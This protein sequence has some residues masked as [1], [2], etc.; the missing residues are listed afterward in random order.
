[1]ATQTVYQAKIDIVADG[2][3]AKKEFKSLG[4]NLTQIVQVGNSMRLGGNLAADINKASRSAQQLQ[5]HLSNAINDG[6]LNMNKFNASLKASGTNVQALTAN[7]TQTGSAGVNA[8]IGLSNQIVAA[9]A[10][11]RATNALLAKM[12]ST[13]MN[14]IRW[15]ISSSLIMGFTGSIRRAFNYVSDLSSELSKIRV[16]TGYSRKEMDELAKSANK[17]AKNLKASTLEVIRGQL[18]YQQQGDSMELAA[19]KAELT[20]KATATAVHASAEEMSNYLTAVWNSYKVGEDQLESFVDK[21][22]A[23]GAKTAASQEEIFTAMEKSAAAANAVGVSYDQLGA[24]IATISS[25][26]RNSAETIGTTLKTVYARI[27]DLK[28]EGPD[29]DGIGLGQVSSTLQKVGIEILDTKSELRDMGVV[30]EEIGEKYQT[31]SEAQQAA[32]VQAIAGKRQYTQMLALF[33]NWD[34]YKMNLDISLNADGTLE[35]QYKE[36]TDNIQSATK[37][38]SAELEGIWQNLLDD[39]A[40]ISIVNGF[41]FVI[42]IIGNTVESLGGFKG[43]LLT[44]GML[45]STKFVMPVVNGLN[46]IKGQ[47]GYLTGKTLQEHITAVQHLGAVS[48]T[49]LV[50][51]S[52]LLTQETQLEFKAIAIRA[53]ARAQYL[54]NEEQLSAVQKQRYQNLLLELDLLTKITQE[55]VARANADIS[56]LGTSMGAAI[57]SRKTKSGTSSIPGFSSRTIDNDIIITDSSERDALQQQL[58][59]KEQKRGSVGRKNKK[60][61]DKD[62]ASLSKKIEETP[63]SEYSYTDKM[64]EYTKQYTQ[65]Q[66][67]KIIADDALTRSSEM[68]KSGGTMGS[69]QISALQSSIQQAGVTDLGNLPTQLQDALTKVQGLKQDLSSLD[70]GEG[71][72]ADFNELVTKLQQ[73]DISLDDFNA[74]LKTL[75]MKDS[76]KQ[77]AKD[78]AKELKNVKVNFDDLQ[79]EDLS[80]LQEQFNALKNKIDSGLDKQLDETIA[81]M[82]QLQKKAG[83]SGPEGSKVVD[84]AIKAGNSQAAVNAGKIQTNITGDELVNTTKIDAQIQKM[85]QFTKSLQDV[86]AA[87]MGLSMLKNA[88]DF[89]NEMGPLERLTQ[90]L[91]SLGMILPIVTAAYKAYSLAKQK[92]AAITVGTFVVEKAKMVLVALKNMVIAIGRAVLG[93]VSALPAAIA[94][95][96]IAGA[97]VAGGIAIASAK[98]KKE[99]ED[100]LEKNRGQALQ[101]LSKKTEELAK[102]TEDLYSSYDKFKSLRDTINSMKEGT[103]EWLQKTMEL[104]TEIEKLLQLYPILKDYVITDDKGNYIGIK[105]EGI[106]LQAGIN[107]SRAMGQSKTTQGT[108]SKPEFKDMSVEVA[109]TQKSNYEKGFTYNQYSNETITQDM[110][111][112]ILR[113]NPDLDAYFKKNEE[114]KGEIGLKYVEWTDSDKQKIRLYA[115]QKKEYDEKYGEY[116]V[117]E[118]VLRNNIQSRKADKTYYD[119]T[120]NE[121]KEIQWIT[122]NSSKFR[123]DAIDSQYEQNVSDLSEDEMDKRLKA[124]LGDNFESIVGDTKEDKRKYLARVYASESGLAG[125]TTAKQELTQYSEELDKEVRAQLKSAMP[126]AKPENMTDEEWKSYKDLYGDILDANGNLVDGK[127]EEFQLVKNIFLR[128]GKITTEILAQGKEQAKTARVVTDYD[129]Q[130]IKNISTLSTMYQKVNSG[131]RL[132]VEDIKQISDSMSGIIENTSDWANKLYEARGNAQE[133]QKILAEM[134]S[135]AIASE[136]ANGRF[137]GMTIAQI[138]AFLENMGLTEAAAARV[139]KQISSMQNLMNDMDFKDA[140]L[141]VKNTE[142]ALNELA[143]KFNISGEMAKWAYYQIHYLDGMGV[144]FSDLNVALDETTGKYAR[145]AGTA[146]TAAEAMI[147]AEFAGK[148]S[149]EKDKYLVSR[150]YEKR[151][152]ELGKNDGGLWYDA[153]G[154]QI[155]WKEALTREIVADMQKGLGGSFT[156]SIN[157]LTTGKNSGNSDPKEDS[158]FDS[159]I[160]EIEKWDEQETEEQTELEEKIQDAIDNQDYDTALNLL[161][162]LRQKRVEKYKAWEEKI[163][164][165]YSTLETEFQNKHGASFEHMAERYYDDGTKKD[166]FTKVYN[167][168]SAEEQKMWDERAKDYS[169]S[170]E[171]INWSKEQLEVEGKEITDTGNQIFDV[172]KNKRDKVINR[173]ADQDTILDNIY[174]KSYL[175]QYESDTLNYEEYKAYENWLTKDLGLSADDPR[176]IE[177]QKETSEALKKVKDTIRE[178]LEAESFAYIDDGIKFGFRNDSLIKAWDRTWSHIFDE[179][180]KEKFATD[181]EGYKELVNMTYDKFVDS[182]SSIMEVA[183]EQLLE[184]LENRMAKYEG[185][186]TILEKH[187]EVSN[188]I[189]DAQ[190]ELNKEL[191]ASLTNYQYL[192]AE[193]RKLLFNEEDY[194]KLS[195][196]LNKSQKNINNLQQE[197]ND[198]I[199]GKTEEQIELIT[200]E[201]ERQYELEMKK[202]EIAKADLE[203]TKKKT[204]LMNT[205]QE[206]NTQMFINGQWTWVADT[207]AVIQAQNEL[208]DAQKGKSDAQDDLSQTLEVQELDRAIDDVQKS[209]NKINKSFEELE[210]KVS[211]QDGIIQTLGEFKGSINGTIKFISE[212]I[213]DAKGNRESALAGDVVYNAGT[214]KYYSHSSGGNAVSNAY[215]YVSG[216]TN[217]YGGVKN[218]DGTYSVKD[219]LTG[220]VVGV[221]SSKDDAQKRINS[222]NSSYATGTSNAKSGLARVIE[223]GSELLA[224]KEGF[225]YEMS[226][227]EMVFNN[228]QFRFLY[229]FSKTPVNKMLNGL[230]HN[231][232]SSIDNSITIN[233]ISIDAKSQEGEALKDILTRILGNR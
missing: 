167:G 149:L 218:K 43:V 150:G 94:G 80:A 199:V 160:N 123:K 47:W 105:Q 44:L 220:N 102:A 227:G 129:K 65:S 190:H 75:D 58:A 108:M 45:F 27:G 222:L 107:A 60:K 161:E 122:N 225:L 163:P 8:F 118:Y 83:I 103:A 193:T 205:L 151:G 53:D 86:A 197:Y 35:K 101:D 89:S 183:Q 232:N 116:G 213:S 203:V 189:R 157:D 164:Q 29:E 130:R 36:A 212:L 148:N 26:T 73:G 202:Y 95:C 180:T 1:M 50:E 19:K 25:V 34:M 134:M 126:G 70:V 200:K 178:S 135:Q 152:G 79:D 158:I 226:G 155:G 136:M 41:G 147:D 165:L 87:G 127:K 68:L 62:I 59:A 176:V 20:I 133:T 81:K 173:R 233:G 141:E 32:V 110:I 119:L 171:G 209:I 177:A 46:Y 221:F 182:I 84:D 132:S 112:G 109:T 214:G 166:W 13:L 230:S 145:L 128:E 61:I 6:V 172:R 159:I 40:I 174:G 52:S 66:T 78:L 90:I 21:A 63:V 201:Y 156:I 185:M 88:L 114:N 138:Q 72:K 219:D 120:E 198:K 38:L 97:A 121:Q 64:T 106:E 4:Q 170:M 93:D 39:E 206:R 99:K 217:R 144:D 15:Q 14:T 11:M 71:A 117:G 85:N 111:D 92:D 211:G 104:H 146:L 204:A 124:R 210:K 224:T 231:D 5:I 98:K 192:D 16:V 137:D 195:K 187:H 196:E 91:M 179:E 31:W 69:V 33:E 184:P 153:A 56:G 22:N 10:P 142:S 186:K 125:S 23:L 115:Q 162:Q 67:S 100:E 51:K 131:E 181:P 143:A 168:L 9:Q 49:Q 2:N 191:Q 169:S 48:K 55:S 188:S 18:I 42:K 113:D 215:T 17:M 74:S 229:E 96:V 57:Q 154:N 228:D 223:Q 139:S 7:L 216:V 82:E 3:K 24:T 54:A 28:I 194:L 12:G 30:I 76:V 37:K 175:R 140:I 208:A 77:K 207:D